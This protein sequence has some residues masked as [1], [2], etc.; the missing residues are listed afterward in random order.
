MESLTPGQSQEATPGGSFE[1]LLL[2][3]DR[4]GII[5]SVSS[6]VV[7]L[8]RFSE[9]QLV[10][11]SL[12]PFL[13]SFN[14]QWE[15][16]LPHSVFDFLHQNIFLPWK[17]ESTQGL[18]WNVHA[19]AAGADKKD[20]IA[21]T[22]VPGLVPEI[23]SRVSEEGLS[24]DVGRTL[25]DL[26]LRTQQSEVRF[27]RLLKLLPGISFI[28]SH[29]LEFSWRGAELRIL[30]GNDAYD[31]LETTAWTDWIHPADQ[32]DFFNALTRCK[33]GRYPVSAKLRLL[34][35]NKK[36]LYLLDIRF[37]V[38]GLDGNI[39]SYEVLWIDLSRQRTAE[40]RLH[41]SA[42]KESLSEISASLTH[43]FNNL[44]TG[45]INLSALLCGDSE[46]DV[47]E[48]DRSNIKLI[49]ESA[50]QAQNLLQQVVSLNKTKLGT[51]E[52]FDL[53]TFI[54]EQYDLIR[55]VLPQRIRFEM[56]LPTQELPVRLD[57]VALARTILN[58]GTN[59]RDAIKGRG[60]VVLSLR[61]VDLANYPREHIFSAL[62]PRQGPAVELQ[63]KDDG[64]G[65]S[66]HIIN[67]I[68]CPYF[69]TKSEKN[70]SGLGLSSVY[71]YAE[72]NGFDFG[73]RSKLGE[74]STMLLLLPLDGYVP[75]RET[76]VSKTQTKPFIPAYNEQLS[77]SIYTSDT[78]YAGFMETNL[79]Q[80]YGAHARM[81]GSLQDVIAWI[82]TDMSQNAVFVCR[83]DF[84][85]DIPDILLEHLKTC[86]GKTNRILLL[87][88]DDPSASLN[89]NG[90]DKTGCFDVV[91]Q[92]KLVPDA[93]CQQI[94]RTLG[95]QSLFAFQ[96]FS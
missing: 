95:H 36:T 55:I 28:Q 72:E 39:N 10:G 77:I 5:L 20:V 14:S 37:P 9:E 44:M 15:D 17:R 2:V 7:Q 68:F 4:A 56:D 90:L 92:S 42:W 52:L 33:T 93:D 27:R 60:Q 22:L 64:C 86:F 66:P 53:K 87:T 35:P 48:V 54:R 26:Y 46:E 85:D 25:H 6:S 47:I 45:I 41:E 30:L 29:E 67:Q 65:I 61:V 19:I 57:K 12:R 81:F 91:L 32:A 76:P 80:D 83:F 11:S 94:L 69:S 40:R 13:L 1:P 59:A 49:W 3:V 31:Q 70:G 51:V 24:Q 23:S 34:L 50:L 89:L 82:N 75:E 71:R 63:F 8:C 84:F 74:G 73:V 96:D 38:I 88:K 79:A 16:L 62:C 21:L 58:F 43:D 78:K 18:G